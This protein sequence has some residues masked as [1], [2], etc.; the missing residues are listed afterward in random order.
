MNNL[1][2]IYVLLA[3]DGDGIDEKPELAAPRVLG[4]VY[5]FGLTTG[6]LR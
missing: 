4:T 5:L 2:G 6:E 1:A 3:R